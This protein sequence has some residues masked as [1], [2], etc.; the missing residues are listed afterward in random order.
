MHYADWFVW[1]LA[2]GHSG[3]MIRQNTGQ[4]AVLGACRCDLHP[5]E[6]GFRVRLP[7]ES[8]VVSGI[9]TVSGR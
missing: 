7:E 4:S 1:M 6:N 2:G 9:L 8:F 5:L 3:R